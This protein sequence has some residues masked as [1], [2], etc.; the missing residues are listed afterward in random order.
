MRSKRQTLNLGLSYPFSDSLSVGFDYYFESFDSE[1]WHLDGVDPDT[2]SSL[3]ALG[4][5]AW[6][7]DVSVFYFSVRY[8]L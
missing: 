5:D 2:I 8:Q 7:Y 4:A 6:N 1:D 3:L